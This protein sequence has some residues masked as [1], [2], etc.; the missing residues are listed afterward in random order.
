MEF[1][2]VAI[3]SDIHSNIYALRKF[4]QYIEEYNVK[5][6]LNCGDFLQIGPNPTEV[7]DIVMS[8]KKFVNILGNNDLALIDRNL[9][10]FKDN[11]ISHQNWVIQQLGVERINRLKEIAINRTVIINKVKFLMVHTR[12][13][14]I[15]DLPLLY[16]E[17]PIEDYTMDYGDDCD[18]VLLG[19]IHYQSLISHWKGKTVINSGSLGCSKDNTINFVVAN[20]KDD[21]IGFEFKKV[22]YNSNPVIEDLKTFNVPD[23][24]NIIKCFF[25]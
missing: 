22:K 20:I 11:E 25:K 8:N 19:H 16:H 23:S 4:L 2:R 12:L 7:Y 18:Y 5:L 24:D 1:E 15:I 13:D 14:N 17:K 21:D 6:I 3:V 10:Q 9:M